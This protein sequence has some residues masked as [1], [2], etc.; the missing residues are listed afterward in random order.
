MSRK[1]DKPIAA[2]VLSTIATLAF[3]AAGT[4]GAHSDDAAFDRVVRSYPG[5][6]PFKWHN[7]LLPQASADYDGPARA[8]SADA[9]LERLTR[10]YGRPEAKWV[11]AMLPEAS[12]DYV[13]VAEGASADDQFMRQ[14]A[15]YTRD[16]LDRG[17]WVNAFIDDDHYAG[18]NTL[19][20]AA[21][22]DGVTTSVPV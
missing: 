11:N 22:G 9:A 20:A 5:A 16:M 19:L 13:A 15:F 21:V 7:P 3:C 6:A 2:T 18:G 14:V 1:T 8:E 17:G 4:A 12:G 10:S